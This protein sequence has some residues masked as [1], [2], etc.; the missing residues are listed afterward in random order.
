MG[1]RKGKRT[2][3]FCE[4]CGRFVYEDSPD[5]KWWLV[6]TGQ[7]K[8]VVRCPQHITEW[9]MRIA[10]KGRSQAAYQW[11]RLSKEQDKYDYAQMIYEPFFMD[12]S[13]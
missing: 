1:K 6:G 2:P 9:T 8:L 11:K 4:K 7:G 10:G 13:W 3:L 12:D 5:F